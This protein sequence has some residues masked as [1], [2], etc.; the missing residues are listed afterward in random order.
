MLSHGQL[1]F[2]EDTDA[3][4]VVRSELH[5][6]QA[7]LSG[8]QAGRLRALR[9][10]LRELCAARAEGGRV[11]GGAPGRAERCDGRRAPPLSGSAV[12]RADELGPANPVGAALWPLA[13][14]AVVLC[15][16]AFASRFA[17]CAAPTGSCNPTRPAAGA[18]SSAATGCGP[19]VATPP[20]SRPTSNQRTTQGN[21]HAIRH[22]RILRAARR[23][24]RPAGL[25][26]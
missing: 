7:V 21:C 20:P 2:L 26:P 3:A 6:H 10:A 9:E 14:D 24:V 23:H 17:S 22:R 5:S 15:T 11:P 16:G 18:L 19:P 1:T 13:E 12:S 25:R 8:R 4:R